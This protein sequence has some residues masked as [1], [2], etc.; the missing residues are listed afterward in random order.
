[1]MKLLRL[2]VKKAERNVKVETPGL[3][4]LKESDSFFFFLKLW[5]YFIQERSAQTVV[6]VYVHR[7][8]CVWLQN[9]WLQDAK[10]WSSN[11]WLLRLSIVLSC[12]M[13]WNRS[14]LLCMEAQ[15]LENQPLKGWW[16]ELMLTETK[17]CNICEDDRE[18]SIHKMQEPDLLV[19]R[20]RPEVW[21][22]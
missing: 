22:S 8:V 2:R 15:A 6:Y 19:D 11:S 9:N 13:K 10:H 12:S 1:M 17:G 5:D 7:L 21:T 14:H 18:I 16:G 3:E 4:F 20:P